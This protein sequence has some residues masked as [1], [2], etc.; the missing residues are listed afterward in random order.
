MSVCAVIVSYHP[1]D[2]IIE[3]VVGLVDQV[4]EIIIVDNGSGAQAHALL[5][6]LREYRQVTIVYCHENLGIAAALN[7]G[8]RRA[9]AAG[10]QWLATFDQDSKV[11]PGMISIMLQVYATYP[12][13]NK[14]ASLCPRYQDKITGIISGSELRVPRGN[15]DRYAEATVV[16]TSGNLIKLEVFDTVNFFNEALFIDY[17]DIEFCLR[18]AAKGLRILEVEDAI[19]IHS[20]GSPTRH[21]FLWKASAVTNHNALRRYYITRNAV[22]MYNTFIFVC[23][24][25]VW[26]NFKILFKIMILLI[27]LEDDRKRKFKAIFLGL[28]D[29]LLGKMGKCCRTI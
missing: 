14:V 23:P 24:N 16:M 4:D 1:A 17:V 27:I 20:A 13:K 15:S 12:E 9:H 18:C 11:T 29:G 5:E 6:R 22:Y 7:I 3:N 26:S 10:Y 25:W 21:R 28:I 19:L 8:V 2:E